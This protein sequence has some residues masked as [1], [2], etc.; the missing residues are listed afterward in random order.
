MPPKTGKTI[1]AVIQVCVLNKLAVKPCVLAKYSISI[2]NINIT[3]PTK[4]LQNQ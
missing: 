2:N 4:I 1:A 3:A